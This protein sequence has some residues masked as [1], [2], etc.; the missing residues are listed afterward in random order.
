MKLNLD[1]KNK[2]GELEADVETLV[3]KGMEQ[4]ER[5]QKDKFNSKHSAKKKILGLK[6]RQKIEIED[7]NVKKKNKRI[8]VEV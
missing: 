8:R 5:T 7:Q 3:E 6:H 4:H 2:K 1:I